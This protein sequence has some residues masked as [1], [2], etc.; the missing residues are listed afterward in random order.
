ME[1][2]NRKCAFH[3]PQEVTII[4]NVAQCISILF[5]VLYIR[6]FE[7]IP[8]GLA[9]S[10]TK[11]YSISRASYNCRTLFDSNSDRIPP[12]PPPKE[13]ETIRYKRSITVNNTVHYMLTNSASQFIILTENISVGVYNETCQ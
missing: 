12:L 3:L 2:L 13:K 8:K 6:R 11:W 1:K 7:H 9:G 4:S 10:H 5:L